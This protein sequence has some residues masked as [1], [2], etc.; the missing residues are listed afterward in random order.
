M[1]SS[2]HAELY[3]KRK[4]RFDR[5]TEEE[6][7]IGFT[8]RLQFDIGIINHIPENNTKYHNVHKILLF[9]T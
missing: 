5:T 1:S 4:K 8:G 2:S 3:K 6:I 9:K 7:P